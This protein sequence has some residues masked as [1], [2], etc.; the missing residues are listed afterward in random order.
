MGREDGFYYDQL[1]INQHNIPLRT[2][3]LVGLIPLI[4]VE[5][6]EEFHIEKLKGFSKRLNGF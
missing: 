2:R 3:S 5:I 1:K 4:A 6:L